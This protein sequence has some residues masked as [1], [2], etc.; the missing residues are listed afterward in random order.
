MATTKE[1][2][3]CKQLKSLAKGFYTDNGKHDRENQSL[4]RMHEAKHQR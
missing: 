4:Q 1:C 2:G 3:K